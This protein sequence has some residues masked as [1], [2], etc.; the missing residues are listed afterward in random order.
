MKFY[1]PK[2][3]DLYFTFRKKPN[4]IVEDCIQVAVDTE[5]GLDVVIQQLV[6]LKADGYSEIFHSEEC[7]ILTKKKSEEDIARERD[8]AQELQREWQVEY[9][10]KMGIL[11]QAY[12]AKLKVATIMSSL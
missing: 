11:E 9:E 4:P 12:Q 6:Q 10:S 2:D 5:G 7:L 3:R 1:H 8:K